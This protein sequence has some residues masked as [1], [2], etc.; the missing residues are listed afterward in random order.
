MFYEKVTSRSFKEIKQEIESEG[1]ILIDRSCEYASRII[2]SMEIGIPRKISG[3]VMNEGLI[4]NLPWGCCVEVPCL[5]D[6][7]GIHPTHIGKLPPQCAA[8]NKS[9]IN[10]QELA[11]EGVVEKDR[12]AILRAITLDPLTS[13][14]T[15]LAKIREMVNERL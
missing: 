6:G 15:S 14:S 11:V 9:N 3:N 10:V 13:A 8:L 4:T 5:V 2:H 7:D 12:E 1:P